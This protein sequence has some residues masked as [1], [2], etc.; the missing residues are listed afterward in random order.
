M[1]SPEAPAWSTWFDRATLA[2]AVVAGA[3]LLFMVVLVCVAVVMRFVFAQPMLGVN[4][5]VQLVSVGVVM[6]GLP[7][8]T[9]RNAHV[10]TDVLDNG[11][12]R[13]GQ[14]LGD[15]L[16]RLLSIVALSFLVR[17]AWLKMLDAFEFG[18]ATNMLGL[19]LWPTYG[20]IAAG[21]GLCILILAMQIAVV[22]ATGAPQE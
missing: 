3:S 12:G 22:F 20:M 9:D 15:V 10:R 7:W 5:I 14:L 1:A 19:P 8:C 17:R 11:I 16:S 21:M 6:L 4:E 13:A 2:L 18:D